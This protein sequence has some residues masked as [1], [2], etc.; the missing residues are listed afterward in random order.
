MKV[1]LFLFEI[2]VYFFAMSAIV[3]WGDIGAQRVFG[4]AL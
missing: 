2:A 1:K 3:Y 4:G